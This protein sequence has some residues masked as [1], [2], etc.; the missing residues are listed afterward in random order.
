MIFNTIIYRL[1][2]L[3][4]QSINKYKPTMVLHNIIITSPDGLKIKF[5][6]SEEQTIDDLMY[7]VDNVMNYKRDARYGKDITMCVLK[8]EMYCDSAKRINYYNNNTKSPLMLSLSI[9]ERSHAKK[10]KKQVS[11]IL[12]NGDKSRANFKGIKTSFVSIDRN[13]SNKSYVTFSKQ[14]LSEWCVKN[15]KKL[16]LTFCE[17]I[18]QYFTFEPHFKQHIF[19]KSMSGGS[20]SIECYQNSTIKEIKAKIKKKCGMDI[21]Q[22][23][24]I[25][26]GKQLQDDHKIY[27]YFPL[28]KI[29]PD[30]YE[31]DGDNVRILKYVI[32]ECSDNTL[33]LVVRLCGGMYHEVSGRDGNYVSLKKYVKSHG[34]IRVVTRPK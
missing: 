7:T 18:Q 16:T 28:R 26:G 34:K 24:L 15:Y 3:I 14:E 32:D 29:N 19:V 5:G 12:Q 23:R 33:H 9:D 10:Q 30:H 11:D 31:L 4:D 21:D 17:M 22:Q 6:Y 8:E 27:N 25:Y 20:I 1:Y 2:P 13:G